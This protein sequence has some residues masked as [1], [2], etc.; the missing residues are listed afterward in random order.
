MG[1]ISK[2]MPQPHSPFPRGKGGKPQ[3]KK[4][5]SF[6]KNIVGLTVHI[7]SLSLNLQAKFFKFKFVFW[8]NLQRIIQILCNSPQNP[9]NDAK[10]A[11]FIDPLYINAFRCLTIGRQLSEIPAN[12]PNFAHF[13]HSSCELHEIRAICAYDQ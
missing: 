12:Q 1:K 9:T 5:K 3:G 6:G 7:V 10:F 8:Q 4:S 11:P 13:T 2:V